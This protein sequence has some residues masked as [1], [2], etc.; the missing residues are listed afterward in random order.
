MPTLTDPDEITMQFDNTV[1]ETDLDPAAREFAEQLRERGVKPD[2]DYGVDGFSESLGA[3]LL[4]LLG[5]KQ[6]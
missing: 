5:V 4:R 1:T 2:V 3:R 6:D